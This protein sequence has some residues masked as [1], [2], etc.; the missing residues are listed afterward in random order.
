MA[1]T[2]GTRA[3]RTQWSV[4]TDSYTRSDANADNAASEALQANWPAAG[5]FATRPASNAASAR[6]FFTSTDTPFNGA[7]FY[8]PGNGTGWQ[9]LN[10]QL[11][12][13]GPVAA[14]GGF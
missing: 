7:V 12:D 10:P 9:L 14:M 13:Y 3:K 4:G 5:A 11:D 6:M 1:K 8:D 2:L